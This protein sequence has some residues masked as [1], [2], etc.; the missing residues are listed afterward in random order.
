MS[1]NGFAPMSFAV[2][3]GSFLRINNITLGYTLPSRLTQRAKISSLRV[4]ATVYN[5]ATITGYS[6]YDP[7][8]NA[9]RSSPLTPGVDYAAYPSGRTFL[10]GINLNF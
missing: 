8:V 10:A 9:R 4:Y 7:D 2:E 5:V 3:D 1:T 6:G